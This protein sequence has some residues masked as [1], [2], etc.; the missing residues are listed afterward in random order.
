M[1]M[2]D[3]EEAT[4]TNRDGTSDRQSPRDQIAQHEEHHG[5]QRIERIGR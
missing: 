1:V 4:V 5:A 2:T 3:T